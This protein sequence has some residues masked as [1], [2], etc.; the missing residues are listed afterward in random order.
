MLDKSVDRYFRSGLAPSTNRAYDSAK[1][2]FLDFRAKANLHPLPISEDLLCRFVGHLA[3]D[4]MAPISIKCYLSAVRH[5]QIAMYMK[6]PNIGDM[7][8]LEQVLKGAKKQFVEKNPIKK[9]RLPMTPDILL[10]MKKVWNREGP[11]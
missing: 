2:R 9:P 8:R 4:G 11:L 7:A 10:Q 6:D 3:D 1:R 5:L